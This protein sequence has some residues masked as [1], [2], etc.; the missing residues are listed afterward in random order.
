MA[1]VVYPYS[2]R[3][4]ALKL[5]SEGHY[6]AKIAEFIGCSKETLKVWFKETGIKRD[7]KLSD[8][9]IDEKMQVW[10]DKL[11]SQPLPSDA[12]PAQKAKKERNDRKKF[13]PTPEQKAVSLATFE[14]LGDPDEYREAIQQ[15]FDK[16]TSELGKESTLQGQVT[17]MTSGLLIAQLK[18]LIDNPPPVVTW[19]DAERVINL[20][21]KT[22]DMDKD[23]GNKGTRIDLTILNAKKGSGGSVIDVSP[24]EIIKSK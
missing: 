21:R 10:G 23:K 4:K 7:M 13:G 2:T 12:T 16:V 8:A 19:S 3:F 22:L 24:N 1:R 14:S 15:H 9:E 20:L 18:G 11:R 5:Y 6:P 17:T